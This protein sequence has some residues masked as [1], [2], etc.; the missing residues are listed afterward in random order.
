M[1]NASLCGIVQ[2]AQREEAFDKVLGMKY[3]ISGFMNGEVV[4]FADIAGETIERLKTTPGSALGSSRY[5]LKDEDLPGIRGLL[6][7]N[8]IRYFFLIGGNDTMDTIHR[9]EAHCRDAGYE[10]FGIGVPKTVDNDLY[11]T[12]HTPGYASAARY[13]MLSALQGGRLGADMQRVDKFTVMQTVGREAGW[14]A[15]AAALAKRKDHEAPHLIYVPERPLV[16]EKVLG[17]VESVIKNFGWCHIV[18]GEGAL[19][20]DG[21]PVSASS[22]RD[23]FTNI[24]FGAMGGASA[25]LNLH[26]LIHKETGF[27]GEFQIPESLPMC[28]SDRVSFVD[29]EEAY[30]CGARAVELALQG[31][32]GVMVSIVRKGNSPYRVEY[33]ASSLSDVAV[34]AKPMPDEYINGEGNFVTE[35][36]LAYAAPLVGPVEEY[37]IL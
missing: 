9:I 16:K 34:R 29:R 21:T 35:N 25:A 20:A 17:D 6:E 3:G 13:N 33:G 10:L 24:E 18:I 11:G 7:R 26:G 2:R 32:S 28:A 27:R 31:V 12:D 8:N 22:T 19:W 36:F 5:K 1:I 37:G 4:D 14:L 30:L 15:A 23:S